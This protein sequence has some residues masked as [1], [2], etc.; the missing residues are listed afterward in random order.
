MNH[1]CCHC[2]FVTTSQLKESLNCNTFFSFNKIKNIILLFSIC[3]F[4]FTYYFLKTISSIFQWK[5]KIII[6]VVYSEIIILNNQ[7]NLTYVFSILATRICLKLLFKSCCVILSFTTSPFSPLLSPAHSRISP[8]CTFTHLN[9]YIN[10]QCKPRQS[11]V[12][13]NMR[14]H[15]FKH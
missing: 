12:G 10:V 5:N 6:I 4:L 8:A 15:P 7:R 1:L 2:P 11:H 9:K 3:I 13:L 14:I